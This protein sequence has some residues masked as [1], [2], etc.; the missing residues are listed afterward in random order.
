M[1]ANRSRVL[2]AGLAILLF[3]TLS[4]A[5]DSVKSGK[6]KVHVSPKQAY[7]FVDGSAIRYGSQT[8]KLTPGSHEVSIRNYGFAP[9]TQTV[10]IESGKTAELKVELKKSG[11][12]VSGPFG[13]IEVKGDREAAVL[14]NGTT[15]DYSVGQVHEFDW[16]WILHRRLL[17][18]PGTYNVTVTRE[19]NTL[20]SAPVSVKAGQEVIVY[21]NGKMKTKSWTKG[22]TMGPHPRF[23]AGFFTTTV[24]IAPVTAALT[25]HSSSVNC[26]QSTELNWN[27]GDA[28]SSP[29]WAPST[30]AVFARIKNPFLKMLGEYF[31]AFTANVKLTRPHPQR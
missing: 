12:N 14:L 15:P 20:F 13:D 17:V 26:G 27:S 22:E 2:L 3:T 28:P 8:I 23:H 7:V 5:T 1:S 16:N 9:V 25:A 30:T 24:P 18:K 21:P 11:D 4:G 29:H 19:G 31:R 6:L 10:Q